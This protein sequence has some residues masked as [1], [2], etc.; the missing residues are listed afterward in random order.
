[1]LKYDL[2]K[3]PVLCCWWCIEES[4]FEVRIAPEEPKPLSA[5]PQFC[6]TTCTPVLLDHCLQLNLLT[7]VCMSDCLHIAG[8]A[9]LIAKFGLVMPFD[10]L[11]RNFCVQKLRNTFHNFF[12]FHDPRVKQ[13]CAATSNGQ[14]DLILYL[15]AVAAEFEL[16]TGPDR[17]V[18]LV[19]DVR[20]AFNCISRDHLVQFFHDFEQFPDLRP[21][22]LLAGYFYGHYSQRQ[23]VHYA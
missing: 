21:L 17:R 1:M 6:Q 14:F 15:R 7:T 23:T 5:N 22:A 19:I 20:N 9:V 4:W 12:Q 3:R 8:R 13:F 11:F 10:D 2:R 16:D 18:F